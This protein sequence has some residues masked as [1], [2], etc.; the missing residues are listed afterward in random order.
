LFGQDGKQ[1]LHMNNHVY[2]NARWCQLAADPRGVG[3]GVKH[4]SMRA[5]VLFRLYL[6]QIKRLEPFDGSCQALL[7]QDLG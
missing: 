1:R 5:G 6:G 3:V 4:R 7:R 2:C